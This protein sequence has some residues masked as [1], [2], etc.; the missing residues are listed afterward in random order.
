MSHDRP[1]LLPS[2]V[3]WSEETRSVGEALR[4][5]AAAA[6]ATGD[7]TRYVLPPLRWQIAADWVGDCPTVD[8]GADNLRI[9]MLP[10]YALNAL[11]DCHGA[12]V[13]ARDGDGE[14]ERLAGLL[15]LYLHHDT[16]LH[17]LVARLERVAAVLC[18]DITA[19][20]TLAT[21]VALKQGNAPE[22]VQ[23][24]TEILTA[25]REAGVAP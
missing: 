2:S 25:W 5:V 16:D 8:H 10:E 21:H 3:E 13:R 1:V 6:S 23:A 18:L 17:G 11:W 4:A 24:V 15:A 19:V 20:R 9:M 7:D 12:L 14:A 22:A